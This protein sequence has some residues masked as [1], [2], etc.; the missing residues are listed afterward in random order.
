MAARLGQLLYWIASW[1]AVIVIAAG[2]IVWLYFARPNYD[3]LG[4]LISA[5]GV[6]IWLGGFLIRYWLGGR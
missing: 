3:P 2:V 5:C 6:I 1:I 4:L